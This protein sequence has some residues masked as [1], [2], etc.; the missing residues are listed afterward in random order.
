MKD[1][2]GAAL[3]LLIVILLIWLY[4]TGRLTAAKQ[5]LEGK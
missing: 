2:S 1:Y 3:L 5:A 4:T